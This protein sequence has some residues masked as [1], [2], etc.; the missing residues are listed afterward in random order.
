MCKL[1]KFDCY[2]GFCFCAGLVFYSPVALLVRT[3]AGLSLSQ[4]F[5]LQALLSTVTFLGEVPAGLLT[6]RIGYRRTLVLAQGI[7]LLARLAM[8]A[9]FL[10][11][12][13]GLFLAESV[14][15][16]LCFCLCSGTESAWVYEVFGE[17]GYVS[18]SAQAAN[19]GT[20]G[21]LIS[22]L[23][24]AGMYRLFGIP[25]LLGASMVSAA[26][27]LV[28][29]L[30]MEQEPQRTGRMPSPPRLSSLFSLIRRGG[31]FVILGGLFTLSWVL[32]HFFYAE[33]LLAFGLDAGWM[34]PLILAYSLVQMLA[35]GILGALEQVPQARITGIFCA[36]AALAMIGLGLTA[37]VVPALALM[38]LLP[39][40]LDI[41]GCCLGGLQNIFVDRFG[42]GDNRAA[43]LSVLGMG[44]DLVEIASLF[45]ASALTGVGADLCFPAVGLALLLCGGW[46]LLT[47]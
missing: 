12:S 28:F 47:Q 8:L 11:K 41:P 45:A 23:G 40:L 36:L 20:A 43:A 4:F 17:A 29:A 16:G 6:D 33:K 27:G 22:T 42:Q 10:L 24:Y 13:P 46:F 38:I 34:T 32:V 14:L 2:D 30:G 39:L 19:C 26:G 18:K 3:Q 44:T 21:F 35:K 31:K 15:E 9:G 1:K 37:R 5:L 25:G 7:L